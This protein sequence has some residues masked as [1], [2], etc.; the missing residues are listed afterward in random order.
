MYAIY[1]N[2]GDSSELSPIFYGFT[3]NKEYLKLFKEQRDMN[4][5]VIIKLIDDDKKS[6][7][8]LGKTYP[9][10]QLCLRTLTTKDSENNIKQVDIVMTDKEDTDLFIIENK[11][12]T[13]MIEEPLSKLF[14]S[15]MMWTQKYIFNDELNDAIRILWSKELNPKEV[16]I[17]QLAL[18]I[19]LHNSHMKGEK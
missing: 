2:F 6:F 17:D 10:R 14:N 16:H 1:W 7:I 19:S 11:L 3:D 15:T 18:F 12:M 9:G 5:Y 13:E 8:K 4:Y